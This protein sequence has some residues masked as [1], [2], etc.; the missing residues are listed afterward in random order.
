MSVSPGRR[1]WQLLLVGSLLPLCWLGMQAVHELGHVAALWA[2]GG[3]VAKVVLHPLT[4]SRTDPGVN[5]RPLLEVWAG[6][7]V[8]VLL[9]LAFL[10]VARAIGLPGTHLLRFFAGF[11]LIA[12]GCY[13]GVGTFD[14]VGDARALLVLG[15]PNWQLG[16]FGVACVPLG[17]YLWHGQGRHFRPENVRPA[18]AAV[19]AALLV[20]VVAAEVLVSPS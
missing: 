7:A 8:G 17:I 10:G 12:N 15:A 9:P 4:I 2:S 1:G 5:P 6:P 19:V 3:T 14:A 11:C 20:A 16:L 18:A 13:I